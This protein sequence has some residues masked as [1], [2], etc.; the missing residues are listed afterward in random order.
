MN[1]SGTTIGV[2]RGGSGVGVPVFPGTYFTFF[3]LT[4]A[5]QIGV[6]RVDQ[7]TTSVTVHA[8]WES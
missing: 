3:G 5:N 2:Q 6:R 1:N 8:T 7:S 4:N